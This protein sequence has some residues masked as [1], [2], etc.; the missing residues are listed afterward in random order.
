[1]LSEIRAQDEKAIIFAEWRDIQR[2]IQVYIGDAFDIVPSIINGTTSAN[3]S[4]R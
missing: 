3:S 2:Q 1:M 4:T